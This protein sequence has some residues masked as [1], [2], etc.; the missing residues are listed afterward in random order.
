VK[1]DELQA[2]SG[3]VGGFLFPAPKFAI[4]VAICGEIA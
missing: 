3:E 4:I 2:E 1:V